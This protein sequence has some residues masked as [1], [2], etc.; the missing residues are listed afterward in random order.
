[1]EGDGQSASE[2]DLDM[3]D[4]STWKTILRLAD[5]QHDHYGAT[6]DL[7][8]LDNAI[9]NSRRALNL[10]KTTPHADS[11]VTAYMANLGS[12]LMERYEVNGSL[13]DLQNAVEETRAAWQ[14]S[15]ES[16][17]S[18]AH[19]CYMLS[20]LLS[21]MY[22]QDSSII[23]LEESVTLAEEAVN[24]A[25]KSKNELLAEFLA[26]LSSRHL[27][28]FDA[29]GGAAHIQRA[30]EVAEQAIEMIDEPCEGLPNWINALGTALQR[31]FELTGDKIDIERAI[32]CSETAI[33]YS[34]GSP[35]QTYGFLSNLSSQLV[36]LYE[37]TG[38]EKALS[39]AVE[40][41]QDAYNAVSEQHIARGPMLMNLA[42][43]YRSLFHHTGNVMHLDEAIKIMEEALKTL[44]DKHAEHLKALFSL[45][46]LIMGKFER[47]GKE[48]FLRR[49]LSYN[50]DALA[51]G[52]AADRLWAKILLDAS[53][54]QYYDYEWG[55][56]ADKLEEALH[57][58]SQALFHAK[59]GE[60]D[61][62]M[63]LSTQSTMLV[64]RFERY[65]RLEDLNE[66][67][68]FERKAIDLTPRTNP[69][70][71][72]RFNKLGV[73]LTK[74]FERTGKIEFL[75]AAAHQFD[76][77]LR[78][79]LADPHSLVSLQVNRSNVYLQFFKIIGNLDYLD[80]A[81]QAVESIDSSILAGHPDEGKMMNNV[82]LLMKERMKAGKVSQE[83][84]DKVIKLARQ[85]LAFVEEGRTDRA[86]MLK[87]LGDSLALRDVLESQQQAL[88]SYRDSWECKNGLPLARLDAAQAYMETFFNI[89]VSAPDQDM[90]Y[91]EAATISYH[92]VFLLSSM[93]DRS[94]THQDQQQI[95][96]RAA[97]LA[98]AACSLALQ[99]GKSAD[100]AIDVLERGRA[101]II[102]YL[103]DRKK[104]ITDLR[105]VDE[106][107][108]ARF[109][110]LRDH[111]SSSFQEIETETD[112]RLRQ[113][114]HNQ[115]LEAYSQL[116]KVIAEIREIPGMTRFLYGPD[117][118]E[119]RKLA[120]NRTFVVVNITNL[121]SDALIVTSTG[122]K[123]FLLPKLCYN[124]VLSWIQKDITV[125]KNLQD[126]GKKNKLCLEL[127]KWLWMVCVGPIIGILAGENSS[128]TKSSEPLHI[129][130][131]GTGL[132]S[133]LPFHAA[134]DHLAGAGYDVLSCT[135]SSYTPTFKAFAETVMNSGSNEA[136][137]YTNNLLLVSM[138][139]TPGEV[140][141]SKVTEEEAEIKA[142]LEPRV[143]VDVLDRPSATTVLSKLK[144]YELVHFACHGVT[145]STDPS[146]SHL[147]L[148]T[149]TVNP[150]PLTVQDISNIH[151]RRARIA[152]LSACS[153]ANN[154]ANRLA[155]EV[156]HLASSFQVCGFQNVVAT[157]WPT[158]DAASVRF[159]SEFYRSFHELDGLSNDHAVAQAVRKATTA[160][161]QWKLKQPLLW[162][163]YVHWGV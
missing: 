46:N 160:L 34:Y 125:H 63:I 158:G 70:L 25:D 135:V 1:M 52:S 19:I 156:L 58:I 142:R 116:E 146:K 115:R 159:V 8:Y 6:R 10:F 163:Q 67:I 49:A 131:I 113:S 124:E 147:K 40:N 83:E 71:P 84:I 114:M 16:D 105:M 132:G 5:V 153:T 29:K 93:N 24:K 30:I 92:A 141:L 47:T 15:R 48:I 21:N 98:T 130:W 7:K 152:F 108:A 78:I 38:D 157:M 128:V 119:R 95:L 151:L 12:M 13:D 60:L 79:P 145:V 123:H 59:E 111:A 55:G 17:P 42:T 44:P 9:A 122:S 50:R 35:A 94:L 68:E 28:Y 74:S 32:D 129:C 86:I 110:T 75:Q 53:L 20:M 31:R 87:T 73:A 45:G 127:L 150:D 162:A 85:A 121:R 109:E 90:D 99:V 96:S 14:R 4:P 138:P 136:V 2:L 66:A 103:I 65:G 91:H 104:D 143:K 120:A 64:R 43:T 37:T 51:L 69:N 77:V 112:F 82:A 133:R 144:D 148:Q 100:E 107:L 36:R 137:N 134:G 126:F 22:E 23:F 89:L 101:L 27:S 102:G 11:S 41:V 139:T 3:A 57:Y 149:R 76:E 81:L 118:T 117:T 154:P 140:G 106:R 54:L 26:N 39:R 155:D 18:Y 72:Q 62:A 61:F 33:R 88:R 97:G 80:R 161:R 56:V